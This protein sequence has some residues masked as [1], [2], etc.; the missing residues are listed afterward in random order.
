MLRF[1]AFFLRLSS[2]MEQVLEF[3]VQRDELDQGELR[4]WVERACPDQAD[5]VSG[6][7]GTH[8]Q[9]GL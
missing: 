4:C 5:R 9:R 7:A 8:G 1:T 6:Y 2:E 3:F